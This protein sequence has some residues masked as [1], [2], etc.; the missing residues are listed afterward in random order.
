MRNGHGICQGDELLAQF[1]LSDQPFP[2]NGGPMSKFDK[3]FSQKFLHLWTNFAKASMPTFKDD[4]CRGGLKKCDQFEWLPVDPSTCKRCRSQ[5]E[6]LPSRVFFIR[7]SLQ[8][9]QFENSSRNDFRRGLLETGGAV[10][11]DSPRFFQWKKPGKFST[12][13]DGK[14]RRFHAK[15]RL[16]RGTGVDDDA[17]NSG[18]SLGFFPCVDA[19]D[20]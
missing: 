13:R 2:M 9:C 1:I 3:V 16:Q 18:G 5:D 14:I 4:N 8:I 20:S 11:V 19:C 17:K 6:I 7:L 15:A 12:I 10:S